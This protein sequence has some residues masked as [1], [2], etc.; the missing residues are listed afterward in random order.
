MED[1]VKTVA[2][3]NKEINNDSLELRLY[4]YDGYSLVF[5]ADNDLTYHH[6]YEIIFE[7]V[8][9]AKLCFLEFSHSGERPLIE[10]VRTGLDVGSTDSYK[11]F[12][13][14]SD[15]LKGDMPPDG[16]MDILALKIR[17]VKGIK[18]H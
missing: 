6:Y 18:L 5:A 1:T 7:D 10:I 12:R 9:N 13:I 2:E 11:H 14:N 15:G 3:I 16:C 8:I 17:F 4:S